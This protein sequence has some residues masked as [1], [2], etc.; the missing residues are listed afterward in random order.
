M[1]KTFLPTLAVIVL[2]LV[3]GSL[4]IQGC[5]KMPTPGPVPVQPKVELTVAPSGILPYG[6][7]CTA[8]WSST[9]AERVSLNNKNVGLSGSV[10]NRLFRDTIFEIFA[11]KG[12]LSAKADKEVK[13][14]DWTTSRLG[15]ITHAPWYMTA[16]KCYRDGILL[17]SFVL[18]DIDKTDEYVYSIEGKHSIY[19][20][21]VRI[22]YMDWIFSSDENSLTY[23]PNTQGPST[24]TISFLGEKKFVITR[25]KPYADGLPCLAEVTYERK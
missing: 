18:S 4:L 5:E 16:N 24:Y 19:R 3:V 8:T 12:S 13:V 17:V 23:A 11:Y 7:Y 1:K 6:A 2:L 14:G 15:L 10:T 21:G 9:D 20:S 25:T 22:G